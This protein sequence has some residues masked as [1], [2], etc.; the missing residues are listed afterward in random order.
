MLIS[1]GFNPIS[2]FVSAEKNKLNI[3]PYIQIRE[4]DYKN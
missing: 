2:Q 4:N 3:A 1:N